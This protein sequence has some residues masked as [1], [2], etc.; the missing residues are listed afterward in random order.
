MSSS[1]G[2]ILIM[3]VGGGYVSKLWWN[4]YRAHQR[5]EIIRGALPGATP[6]TRPAVLIAVL[7]ALLILAAET[8][9][10]ILL[11][12]S[13]EQSEITVLFGCYTLM[14]AVIEEIIFRG[15]LVVT[16]RG[17]RV[18]WAAI[19]GASLLFA[20]VHPFLWLWEDGAWTWT[21]TAK[22]WFS[23]TVV[24]VSS[25]WFYTVR[26]LPTNPSASLLP[27]FAAHA[28]KNL[29]VF[30]IKGLQGFVIGWW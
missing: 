15:F 30:A 1:P 13:D 12:L 18:K 7:G 29:G 19:F 28:A 6:S 27:C 17:P 8:G 21:L 25:L 5:G 14:A 26:F 16:D 2:L 23:T 3:L 24:F 20:A 9:G 10:E 22:G 4:D 11:G